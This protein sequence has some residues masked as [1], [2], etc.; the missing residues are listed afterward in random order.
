MHLNLNLNLATHY[1][2]QSQAIRVMTEDWV[3][4]QIFCPN[5]GSA[6]H[7]F[8]NNKPVAD[9][10]CSKCFEEFELKSK[11]NSMGQKILDGAYRTMIER[12]NSA[13]NPSFF[14]LNY[15]F[16]NYSVKNFVVIPNF[17]FIPGII[18]KRKPLSESAARAGWV[19]CNILLQS[20]PQ[21][22]KIYFVKNG[23]PEKK[24]DVLKTWQ[25]T[26]FLKD[27]ERADLKGWIL[28]IMICI[29]KLNKREFSI[30]DMYSFEKTLSLKYRNNRHIK[31]KIRQQLQFL[32]DKG[33]LEFVSRGIYRLT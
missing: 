6:I 9:F 21:S 25:K 7:D 31:D 28:D 12:L 14:F 2:S 24:E 27:S 10:Y 5:C 4:N 22:G 32:R 11:K 26:L 20:I 33:Y 13:E 18:E 15:S 1:K 30:G 17:F 8:E 23:N 16:P 19:G 29:D 3:K